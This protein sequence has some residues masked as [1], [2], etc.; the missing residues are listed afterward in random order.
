MMKTNAVMPPAMRYTI[1]SWGT[2]SPS[3]SPLLLTLRPLTRV[4]EEDPLT[5]LKVIPMSVVVVTSRM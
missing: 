3:R 1:V 4:D 2:P 5:T